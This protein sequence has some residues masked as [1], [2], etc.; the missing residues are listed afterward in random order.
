MDDG[1]PL[2]KGLKGPLATQDFSP[3]GF[4]STRLRSQVWRLQTFPL[5]VA[6]RVSSRPQNAGGAAQRDHG[7]RTQSG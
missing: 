4:T 5:L 1:D 2:T 3:S 6:G 7:T